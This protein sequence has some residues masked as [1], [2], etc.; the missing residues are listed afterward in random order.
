MSAALRRGLIAAA[1]AVGAGASLPVAAA[2]KITF[3]TDWRAE[4]EH[5]GYY[6]AQAE[7]LYQAAGLEVTIRQGGPQV[8]HAQLLAA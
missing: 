6:Q 8:N 4:A 1:F 7:G 2:D 5:G 3:G